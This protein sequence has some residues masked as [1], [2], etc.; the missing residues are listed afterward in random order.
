MEQS[1]SIIA[2]HMGKHFNNLAPLLQKFHIGKNELTGFADVERGNALAKL[3]CGI[4]G[5]PKQGLKT[6]L[7]VICDRTANS[8]SW[9]RNFDGLI[10]ASHFKSGDNCIVEYLGP[11]AMSF[12]AVEKQ[13]ELHYQYY[14]TKFL[15]IPMPGFLS[16]KVIAWEKE[17]DGEYYFSVEVRMF[18]VGKV[19]AY[20]GQLKLK[21]I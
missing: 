2:L 6:P 17:Q 5:F 14:K 1:N 10:M 9:R 12:R 8:M 18:L 20:K 16:P 15:G 13:G 4:L 21:A 11:L 7:T 3:M 19:I